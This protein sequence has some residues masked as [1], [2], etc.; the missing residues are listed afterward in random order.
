MDDLVKLGGVWK[1]TSGQGNEYFVGRIGD[2]RIVV[3]ENR[4][5]KSDADP[6]HLILLGD[7]TVGK[8]VTRGAAQQGQRARP[9]GE[10]KQTAFKGQAPQG[11]DDPVP[12]FAG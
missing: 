9:T 12:D 6:T 5:R 8:P 10:A 4:D 2:V 11:F 3:A 1:K 7:A